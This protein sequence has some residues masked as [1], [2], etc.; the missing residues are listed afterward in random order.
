MNKSSSKYKNSE[1]NR[2]ESYKSNNSQNLYQDHEGKAVI[3]N[4]RLE[5][6]NQKLKREFERMASEIR[7][8]NDL[9]EQMKN[10]DDDEL[11]MIEKIQTK[12]IYGKAQKI[13]ISEIQKE[14][15]KIKIETDRLKVIIRGKERQL[16]D[17][18]AETTRLKEEIER[19]KRSTKTNTVI[20]TE[21]RDSPD[22]LNKLRVKDSLLRQKDEEITNLRNTTSKVHT[23]YRDN[24]NSEQ[25]NQLKQALS[26][27]DSLLDRKN[28]ELLQM[29]ENQKNLHFKLQNAENEMNRVRETSGSLEQIEHLKREVSGLRSESLRERNRADGLGKILGEKENKIRLYVNTLGQKDKLNVD[30]QRQLD[31][32]GDSEDINKLKADNDLLR[33]LLDQKER[34]LRNLNNRINS[35]DRQNKELQ[36]NAFNFEKDMGKEVE[37]KKKI[38]EKMIKENQETVNHIKNLKDEQIL[39]MQESMTFF[40]NQSQDYKKELTKFRTSMADQINEL[41]SIIGE[42]NEQIKLMKDDMEQMEKIIDDKDAV[43]KRIE[44]F[45]LPGNYILSN[46]KPSSVIE[47]V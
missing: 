10:I 9:I 28:T 12:E 42:K 24:P 26:S 33:K 20:K 47:Y 15:E 11:L 6:E 31:L 2:R 39:Q 21:Y 4:I 1:I 27:R 19:L 44:D 8:L 38:Y 7:R 34:E 22:L 40:K 16:G 45:N 17:R 3:N 14:T 30:L 5:R 29:R 37:E 41:E 36:S 18:N 13:K 43:L 32:Q 23:I 46:L 35:L 25:I